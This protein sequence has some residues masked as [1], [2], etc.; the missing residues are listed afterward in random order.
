V[1]EHLEAGSYQPAVDEGV[2]TCLA[3]LPWWRDG[4]QLQ[5]QRKAAVAVAARVQVAAALGGSSSSSKAA[6]AGGSGSS[7]GGDA[8]YRKHVRARI[9]LKK[10]QRH[11]HHHRPV[12]GPGKSAL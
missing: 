3:S 1:L 12:G 5:Q 4:L 2:A 7:E 10:R 9:W 8:P 6:A 11:H